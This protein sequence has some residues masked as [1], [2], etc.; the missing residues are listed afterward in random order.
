[1]NSTSADEEVLELTVERSPRG[2]VWW[3]PIERH[4]NAVIVAAI[5]GG[6]LGAM[7][8]NVLPRTYEASERLL[9]VPVDDPTAPSGSNAFEAANSTLPLVVAVLRSRRVAQETVDQLHLDVAWR[10]SSVAARKRLSERL[11]VSTDRKANQLTV[12]F[13]DGVPARARAVVE[14]VA[15]RARVLSRE[16]WTERNREHRRQLESD[17]T[18]VGAELAAAEE[19]FRHFRERTHVVDLP[20]QIKATVEQAAALERLRIDKTLELRFARA[21]GQAQSIEVQKAMRE[22]AA[23]GSELDRLR[24][25]RG[26]AGPLLPFDDLPQLEVE[27]GR[28]KRVVDEQAARRELLALK[29]SQLVAAEARPDGLAEVVDPP[30]VPTGASGPS[31]LNLIAAGSLA[32]G[33]LAA[34]LALLFSHRRS[35]IAAAA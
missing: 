19:A 25:G 21:F 22:R 14:A 15:E 16:L 10:I 32:G 34:L 18:A 26:D 31:L 27:H 5:I 1:M 23:A 17:L 12:A 2:E 7:A 6:S 33:L 3:R 29:V 13:E 20:A 11:S 24:R 9:V 28:L 4:R 8:A 35:V 30:M